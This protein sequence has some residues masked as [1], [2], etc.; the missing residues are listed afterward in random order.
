M[1]AIHALPMNTHLIQFFMLPEEYHDCAAG[2][3]IDPSKLDVRE[4]WPDYSIVRLIAPRM[5]GSKLYL[6]DL[7][8]KFDPDSGLG[9]RDRY[10]LLAR[11]L[12]QRVASG[13]WG[14]NIRTGDR[15]RYRNI[16]ISEG[17]IRMA[18]GGGELVQDAAVNVRFTPQ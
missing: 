7:A 17:A 12:K 2:E 18:R 10:R 6:A 14:Q 8:V 15:H 11:S 9:A 16:W 13:V 3:G 5:E 1:A 4:T